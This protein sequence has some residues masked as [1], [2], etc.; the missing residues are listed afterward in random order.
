M[1]PSKTLL[2][3]TMSAHR[4]I[5]TALFAL[6]S[7]ACVPGDGNGGSDP[8]PAADAGVAPSPTSDAGS[9]PQDAGTPPPNDAGD[10]V[11]PDAGAADPDPVC[12]NNIVEADEECDD[13]NLQDG[14]GCS[15]ECTEEEEDPVEVVD[16][17]VLELDGTVDNELTGGLVHGYTIELAEA[18]AYAFGTRSDR[19]TKCELHHDANAIAND[20]DSG[21]G[22]NCRIEIVVDAGSYELRV[23][24]YSNLTPEGPYTVYA[25]RL[26]GTVCGDGEVQPGEYCDD[27]NQI[28]G[29]GC[30][31]LCQR[32]PLEDTHGNTQQD[33]TAINLGSATD[34]LMDEG[35]EDWFAIEL[36]G[37]AV[38]RF[39]TSGDGRADCFL[40]DA[41]S[42]RA[43]DYGQG[44][45][46][47]CDT[48]I[49]VQPEGTFYLRLARR[50]GAEP[51]A[52]TLHVEGMPGPVC[53]D[54]EVEHWEQ[55]DD[56]NQ[57]D[58]D[59]CSAECEGEDP[60]GNTQDAAS[61][62]TLGEQINAGIDFA[63]DEDWFHFQ[64][65]EGGLHEFGTGVIEGSPSTD[66]RCYLMDA[67]GVVI[68]ENDDGRRQEGLGT[69]ANCFIE[70][71]LQANRT[72]YLR[73]RHFR[74]AG[75]GLYS[76]LGR[77]VADAVCGN[78]EL[79]RGEQCDDG[80]VEV[81][82]GCDANCLIEA[83][84]IEVGVDVQAAIDEEGE[85]DTYTFVAP[86][87][88][89]Y[90][91]ATT[92][93]FDTKCWLD[94]ATGRELN[95]NDDGGEGLN[96]SLMHALSEGERYRIRVRFFNDAL[97]GPYLLR[98][99]AE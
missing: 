76:M 5:L 7:L 84:E 90:T 16:Q 17:G 31:R 36:P 82:D 81:G 95:Y 6:T 30:S 93:D 2:G 54:G 69:G 50:F 78:G 80:D 42:R 56:N 94:D 63:G 38:I 41:D 73:V 77:R 61:N 9:S 91:V 24:L 28:D 19:D 23:Q 99:V 37:R 51:G 74:D 71:D 67:D 59:G 97:T 98:V 22:T 64:T 53:G 34:G 62:Y 57:V 33:A 85:E 60:H 83:E 92:G 40:H 48:T 86:A 44:E 18:G 65:A 89:N 12:G 10:V 79:E 70:T 88:G 21:D 27:S 3:G 52:Y 43:S 58:G 8:T 55:C 11:V 72:F 13:G 75:L 26:E 49:G 32:E 29:D 4:S 15:S 14:D 68:A 96:C 47:H 1:L 66:T 45:E 87:D 46:G 20:D 39:Y 35:D 25:E